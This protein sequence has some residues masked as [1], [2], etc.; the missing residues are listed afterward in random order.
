M[1]AP[2]YTPLF[3]TE[4]TQVLQRMLGWS[5]DLVFAAL[6]RERRCHGKDFIVSLNTA[7]SSE[8]CEVKTL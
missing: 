7:I 3:T 6:D 8:F 1:H 2:Y 4:C 5:A